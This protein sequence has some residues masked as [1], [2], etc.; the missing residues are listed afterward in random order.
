MGESK[1]FLDALKELPEHPREIAALLIE[2]GIKGRKGDSRCCPIAKYLHGVDPEGML[3]CEVRTGWI[4]NGKAQMPI[5]PLPVIQ[6][7]SNFDHG[8]YPELIA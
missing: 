7:I 5:L 4:D 2:K 8:D 6:F 1:S 3:G